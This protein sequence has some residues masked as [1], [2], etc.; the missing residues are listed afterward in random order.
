MVPLSRCRHVLSLR[1]TSFQFVQISLKIIGIRRCT[2]GLERGA[3]HSPPSRNAGRP[4]GQKSTLSDLVGFLRFIQLGSQA[5]N[6][7]IE[8]LQ[9]CKHRC[10]LVLHLAMEL[11][12]CL[13]VN[14][15]CQCKMPVKSPSFHTIW[16]TVH[17]SYYSLL[18]S[19]RC[20]NAGSL[21]RFSTHWS[22]CWFCHR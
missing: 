20:R 6:G 2:F 16:N 1:L 13:F 9:P 18:A 8:W 21:R 3:K 7:V 4:F 12:T 5:S 11:G 15:V 10:K 19:G 14:L 17:Q 22:C